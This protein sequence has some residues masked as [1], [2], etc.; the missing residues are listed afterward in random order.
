M[1]NISASVGR[2]GTNL[3]ADVETIQRLLN[4]HLASIPPT[5]ALDDDGKVGNLT[6]A[7]IE[8]FQTRVVGMTRPDG[9]V[10]P[11]GRTL[12][13]LNATGLPPRTTSPSSSTA[14][15]R[16][17]FNNLWNSYPRESSPCDQ[18]WSNQCAVRMSLTLNTEKTIKVN[19]T[20]YSEPKCKHGHARGA[21]SLAV[22]L[23]RRHLGR[24]QIFSDPAAAKR[25]L[26]TAQG[27]IFFKDC[28][29]RAGETTRRGDHID[30]WKRGTTKTYDDPGNKSAQIWFWALT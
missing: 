15:L 10:D 11:G 2:R 18:G 16:P 24:P 8:R 22:W 29:T 3:A 12:R 5:K 25:S 21:E 7:A 4:D 1:P 27:I 14:R 6:I 26:A 20:T 23:W 9:R 17:S 30:L 19:K 28:F 13:S